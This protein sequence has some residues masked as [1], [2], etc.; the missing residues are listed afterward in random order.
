MMA[1]GGTRRKRK[2]FKFQELRLNRIL[3][4]ICFRGNE[5]FQF[6]DRKKLFLVFFRFRN[7]LHAFP[8]C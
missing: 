1:G 5:Q 3:T 8:I 6:N 2:E 7:N 4:I